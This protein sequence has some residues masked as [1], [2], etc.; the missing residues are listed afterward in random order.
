MALVCDN[1]LIENDLQD[2][3]CVK[4]LS[5][6]TLLRIDLH[7][8]LWHSTTF[9]ASTVHCRVLQTFRGLAARRASSSARMVGCI[10]RQNGVLAK[11]TV[12]VRT[13]SH[14][15]TRPPERAVC[16]LTHALAA[17]APSRRREATTQFSG[18]IPTNGCRCKKKNLDST[19]LAKFSRVSGSKYDSV[20][21]RFIP[22]MKYCCLD[23]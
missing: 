5:A 7:G 18:E 12:K 11:V 1:F 4:I 13:A 20:K 22:T 17:R 3:F 16:I 6:F 15:N 10:C 21:L 14:L 2:P 9:R 23:Q 8:A 19:T